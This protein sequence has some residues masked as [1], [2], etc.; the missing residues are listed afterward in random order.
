MSEIWDLGV[1]DYERNRESKMPPKFKR[2]GSKTY[3]IQMSRNEQVR[4][5][6]RSTWLV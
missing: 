3:S 4:K 2:E 6:V 1:R 5:L